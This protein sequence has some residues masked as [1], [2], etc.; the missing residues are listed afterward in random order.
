MLVEHIWTVLLFETCT[1]RRYSTKGTT[2]GWRRAFT[3]SILVQWSGCCQFN[4]VSTVFKQLDNGWRVAKFAI[5]VQPNKPIWNI[6][7]ESSSMTA[8]PSQAKPS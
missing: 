5:K 8:K 7:Q 4:I 6:I 1:S 2:N 3:R